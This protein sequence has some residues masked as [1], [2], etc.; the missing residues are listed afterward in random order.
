MG[1]EE[2]EAGTRHLALVGKC[3]GPTETRQLPFHLSQR[4]CL[5]LSGFQFPRSQ[6]CS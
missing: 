3:P 1:S 5:H 4:Y 6:I 2:D